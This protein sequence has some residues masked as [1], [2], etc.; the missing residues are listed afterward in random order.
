MEPSPDNSTHTPNNPKTPAQNQPTYGEGELPESK[1]VKHVFEAYLKEHHRDPHPVL[2]SLLERKPDLGGIY[3]Q[4]LNLAENE[5]SPTYLSKKNI[6][7]VFWD[8]CCSSW[9]S[10]TGTEVS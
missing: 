10:S 7:G 4:L 8:F 2:G 3:I 1:A 9:R 6:V 5:R